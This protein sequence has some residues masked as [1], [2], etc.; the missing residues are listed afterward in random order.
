MKVFQV[1]AMAAVV[2]TA[3]HA[4]DWPQWMGPK[5]DNVW[6][7]EGIV[8]LLPASGPK[9][10][11][12]TPV[13][14]GYAGPAVAA[15]KVF[16][17]DYVTKE[18]V[19]VDNFSRGAFSGTERVLCL[20]EKTGAVLWKHEYPVKYAISYPAGPRCTPNVDGGKVYTLGAEGNLFCFD[21][22]TGKVA[23]AKDLKAEYKTNSALWGY[24]S[25]PLIDGDKL[26][27]LV[28]GEGTHTVAFDKNTGKELW[29]SQTAK[30]QGYCPPL[31]IN[32]A[33]V[34][35][36]I[37]PRPDAVAS[38]DPETGKLL[39]SVPYEASNG[40]I[41]M[42]PVVKDDYLF[43]AGYSNK[44]MLLKLA[45]DKP[46]AEV[47]WKDKAKQAISPV[48]VQPIL[49]EGVMYGHDQDG[50]MSAVELPSG[51]RLWSTPEPIGKRKVGS[52]T[53]FITRLGNRHFFFTETGHLVTGMLSPKGF[54]ETSRA[55]LLEPTNNAFGRPVVWC[56]PA[57]ANK[58]IYVRNDSEIAAFELAK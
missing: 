2:A 4:D 32:A 25:H 34:R 21:T 54:T 14:G 58:R 51:Q 45:K 46:G 50:E 40:S 52:G 23:W 36:L 26:I 9:A 18:D 35:Q 15:G 57:Y 22:A 27:C 48:N 47:V 3:A 31:I 1:L 20:D 7:E 24:A 39:W 53:A 33:G 37:I 55:K 43:I 42:T 10:A 19:K 12:R 8:E 5:R 16:V 17:T 30:E 6:R 41:I 13:A 38:L 11:W 29:R 44:N 56:A 49:F 28:G